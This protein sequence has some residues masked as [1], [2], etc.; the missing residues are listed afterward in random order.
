MD[1]A[2]ITGWISDLSKFK[3][4]LP[5]SNGTYDVRHSLA[6]MNLAMRERIGAGEPT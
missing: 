5:N 1:V 2:I 6:E 4:H 3:T